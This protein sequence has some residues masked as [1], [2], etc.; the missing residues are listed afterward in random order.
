VNSDDDRPTPASTWGPP[1]SD[2]DFSRDLPPYSSPFA[3]PE[4]P[5]RPEP[6]AEPQPRRGWFRVALLAAIVGALVGAGAYGVADRI[7]D[8]VQAGNRLRATQTQNQNTRDSLKFVGEA[9]DLQ[10]VLEK[11]QPAV[12]SIGVAGLEGRGAG[13]GMILTA[14]GEVLTNRHVIAGATRIR[15]TLYGEN[16]PREADLIGA[17]CDDGTQDLALIKI[18]GASNLPTVELGS[19]DAAQVG[20]DV[21]AIGNALAL[22]G[23]PTVTTGIVSAKD[24]ALEGLDGLI[25]TDTAINQGNSGGPLVNAAGQVIGV[26]TAVIRGGAEGIGFSIAIDNVKP[27]I[28]DL[29]TGKTSGGGFLGISSQSMT[30]EIADNLDVPVGSGAVIVEVVPGTAADDAGL[31]RGDVIVEIDGQE[32]TSAANVGTIVRGKEPGDEVEITF[33][34]GDEKQTVTATLG[35]RPVTGD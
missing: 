10:A 12:V 34:R 30:P 27:V 19:S 28:D 8:D 24:R 7:D 15:V 3:P 17:C 25:Q 2:D 29:R 14:D 22:P 21:V 23:G 20:D 26:N 11:V 1:R 5:Q 6:A 4:P 18:R 16:Q 32:I 35:S 9:L 31:E 33:Y 13:T